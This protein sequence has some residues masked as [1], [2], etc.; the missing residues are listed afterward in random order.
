M[1]VSRRLRYEIFRR[2]DFRCRYCGTTA[3]GTELEVDH[4]IPEALGG[5]NL[6]ENLVTACRPCNAGKSSTAPDAPIVTAVSDDALR[7]A[8]AMRKAAAIQSSQRADFDVY[9]DRFYN[10]WRPSY[11]L[12]WEWRRSLEQWFN[13]GVEID[14]VLE[15][16]EIAFDAPGID[17]R[18]KYFCGVVWNKVRERQDIA[19]DIIARGDA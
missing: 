5:G 13:L 15:C 9:C 12:P 19:K 3:G 8:E 2:D 6:P 17:W 11:S 7:W 14:L 16:L 1:P 10:A 4:V 18:W